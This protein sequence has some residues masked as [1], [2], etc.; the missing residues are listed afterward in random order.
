MIFFCRSGKALHIKVKGFEW[1]VYDDN[2]VMYAEDQ[3]NNVVD[4]IHVVAEG[5]GPS[6]VFPAYAIGNLLLH[7]DAP[8]V[9]L[10]IKEDGT[11]SM[12]KA[13]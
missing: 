1:R 11:L 6:I 2:S 7:T 5:V 4:L 3:H 10:Y 12:V 9:E 8:H 13:K